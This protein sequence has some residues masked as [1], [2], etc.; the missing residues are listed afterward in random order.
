MIHTHQQLQDKSRVFRPT[1]FSFLL[2][3][4]L[5]YDTAKALHCNIS[6]AYTNLQLQKVICLIFTLKC[7]YQNIMPHIPWRVPYNR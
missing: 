1:T 4:M 3:S 5:H 7:V 6:Y 2:F